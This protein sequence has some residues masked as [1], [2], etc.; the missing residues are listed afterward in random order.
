LP[1]IGNHKCTASDRKMY[2]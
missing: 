2:T 1:Y